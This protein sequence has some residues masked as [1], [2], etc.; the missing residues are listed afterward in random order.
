MNTYTG[1]QQYPQ[2]PGARVAKC[3]LLTTNVRF[4]DPPT[5]QII[6]IFPTL[7][8]P[9]PGV[10][11]PDPQAPRR[12]APALEVDDGIDSKQL[13]N[14]QIGFHLALIWM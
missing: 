9:H 11:G 4:G 3:A 2:A 6:I 10:R 14:E 8:P 5:A 1:A 13:I 7:T 12:Y